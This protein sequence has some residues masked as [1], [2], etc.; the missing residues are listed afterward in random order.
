MLGQ[1]RKLLN[2][3]HPRERF[4]QFNEIR[5]LTHF[6]NFRSKI[7]L[8]HSLSRPRFRVYFHYRMTCSIYLMF[9]CKSFIWPC[10]LDLRL[11]SL[12]VSD[13]LRFI[14]P[15]HSYIQAFY[16][17]LLQSYGW[18]N[19]ITLPSH[20]TD[21]A[22]APCQVTYHRGQKRFTFLKSRTTI[23]LFTLSLPGHYDKE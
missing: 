4:S 21:N 7:W 17:S 20:G 12:S 11:L 15:T 22:H 2:K 19:M 8:C 6:T 14:H 23:C 3:P 16:D 18:L 9:S 1:K 10:Y 13:E 5:Q